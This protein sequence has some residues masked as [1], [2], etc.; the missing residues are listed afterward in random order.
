MSHH[1]DVVI[2]ADAEPRTEPPAGAETTPGTDAAN[3]AE[4]PGVPVEPPSQPEPAEADVAAEAEATAA[5][6]IPAAGIGHG[7]ANGASAPAPE[8]VA[9]E[10]GLEPELETELEPKTE[11]AS[12]KPLGFASRSVHAD[13]YISAHRA[14]APPLH[15]STTFR[16]SSNPDDLV[17]WENIDVRSAHSC[18]LSPLFTCYGREFGVQRTRKNANTPCSRRHRTTRTCTRA[19]Q[20]QT[21]PGSKPS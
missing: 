14:V 12:G 13:D 17:P 3:G 9:V 10:S 5:A 16:Y 20:R 6:N 1:M 19:T 15:V 7:P 11:L 18:P 21:P 8:P 2:A 4:A